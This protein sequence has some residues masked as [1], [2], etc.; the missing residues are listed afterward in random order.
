VIQAHLKPGWWYWEPFVGSGK[1][2]AQVRCPVRVGSDTNR[3]IICLLR[4]VRDGWVPP[5]EVTEGDYDYWNE[6]RKKRP[7]LTDPMVGFVGHGC[8][9]GGKFFGG[10]ARPSRESA[11]DAVEAKNSLVKMRPYLQGVKFKTRSYYDPYWDGFFPAGRTVVYCDPPYEGTTSV[12][13]DRKFDSGAFWRWATAAVSLGM[14][15]LVSEYACPFDWAEV[16]WKRTMK[17]SLRAKDGS[18][19]VEYLFRLSKHK[20]GMLK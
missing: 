17:K 7:D 20:T 14:T 11:P 16:V 15:V 10:F 5:A 9:F 1:V 8:S 19:K 2:I 13:N 3:H 4:R 12:G 18:S 6:L